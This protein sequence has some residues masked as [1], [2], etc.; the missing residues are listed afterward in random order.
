MRYKNVFFD[1]D[2]TLWD[3]SGNAK[4]SFEEVF[5]RHNLSPFY[6]S[7]EEF[8]TIY[9]QRNLELWEL[10]GAGDISKDELNRQRFLFPLATANVPDAEAVAVRYSADFLSILPLKTQLIPNAKEVLE[11]LFP[12]Y[13]LYIISN[14]FRELQNKKMRLS[15]IDGYFKRVILSEDIGMHKPAPEI[16]R[17]ALSATQ[18]EVRESIMVGDNWNAD[19]NGARGA[20]MDQV[21]FNL[22]AKNDLPFRPTYVIE[23][24]KEILSIL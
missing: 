5:H 6:N 13:N 4:E 9:C 23:N 7:F 2:D 16:F 17:F 11:Y 12:R 22:Y 24:L 1:L 18:S 8:Y 15:G 21:F 10:Y 14:G 19:I 3:F 20:G